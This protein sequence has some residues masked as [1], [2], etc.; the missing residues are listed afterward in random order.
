MKVND[1]VRFKD[2]ARLQYKTLTQKVIADIGQ[3]MKIT[4]IEQWGDDV[5]YEVNNKYWF[6]VEMIEIK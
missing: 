5:R 1:I 6:D 4:N 3:D 2:S